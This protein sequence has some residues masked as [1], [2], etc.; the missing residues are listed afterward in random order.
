MELKNELEMAI[1]ITLSEL[2][3]LTRVKSLLEEART[4]L[5]VGVPDREVL[6][7]LESRGVWSLS[8]VNVESDRLV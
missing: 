4:K 8:P 7:C 1:E 3:R 2:H 6:A 5:A